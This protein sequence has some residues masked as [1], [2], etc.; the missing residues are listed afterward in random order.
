MDRPRI[1]A[2]ALRRNLVVSNLNLVAARALI[3]LHDNTP[4]DSN[5]ASRCKARPLR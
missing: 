5:I 1:D 3:T 2:A 4:H